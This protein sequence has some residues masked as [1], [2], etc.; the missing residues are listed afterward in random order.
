MESKAVVPVRRITVPSTSKSKSAPK[1]PATPRRGASKPKTVA[2]ANA[3]AVGAECL[4]LFI[5]AGL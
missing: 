4:A 1:L 5:A 2:S 3:L